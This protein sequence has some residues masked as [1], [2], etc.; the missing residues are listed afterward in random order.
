MN[1][2]SK[3]FVLFKLVDNYFVEKHVDVCIDTKTQDLGLSF[4]DND[5]FFEFQ[6]AV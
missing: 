3:V 5:F 2:N 1:N 4:I 6:E